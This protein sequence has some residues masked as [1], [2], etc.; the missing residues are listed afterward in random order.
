[1]NNK[2]ITE[3]NR[4]LEI[5]GVNKTLLTESSIFD[6]II[7]LAKPIFAT[8]AEKFATSK[9]KN[10]FVGTEEISKELL[11]KFLKVIDNPSKLVNLTRK[12][13]LKLYRILATDENLVNHVYQKGMRD[14]IKRNPQYT[15]KDLVKKVMTYAAN[16]NKTIKESLNYTFNDEFLTTLLTDKYIKKI[17]D[18]KLNRFVDEVTPIVDDIIEPGWK[19][20]VNNYLLPMWAKYYKSLIPYLTKND[21]QLIDLANKRLGIIKE[22]LSRVPA[23]KIHAD[24]EQLFVILNARKKW[25][26]WDIDTGFVKYLKNNSDLPENQLKQFLE[27]PEVAEVINNQSKQ[28]SSV[29]KDMFVKRMEAFLDQIPGISLI[30]DIIKKGWKDANKLKFF[31]NWKRIGST[32]VWKNPQL[33]SEAVSQ[34]MIAGTKSHMLGIVTNFIVFELV[35][36]PTIVASLKILFENEGIINTL[37]DNIDTIKDMCSQGIL[38]DC[39]ENIEEIKN[40]NVQNWKDAYI[41]SLPFFSMAYNEAN[42]RNTI[43]EDA[44]LSQFT[45]LDEFTNIMM[46]FY[47]SSAF[48]PGVEEEANR[49]ANEYIKKQHKKLYDELVRRGLDPNGGNDVISVLDR[50]KK[51]DGN[52]NG[53]NNGGNTGG[54][55]NGG[56]QVDP[57]INNNGGQPVDPPVN[58]TDKEEVELG[59]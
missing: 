47:K 18:L 25:N 57:P 50:I 41:E 29:V 33:P 5:M 46:R 35:I 3:V 19:G 26:T 30:Q 59:L 2:I 17:D 27:R 13:L 15:E 43:S 34:A 56:Q 24:L 55:N 1:M 23:L 9:G 52:N 14:F 12:E 51:S 10:I 58:N 28:A 38:E 42:P 40:L 37:N 20:T 4:T 11:K 22:K 32:I 54:N 39:P 49:M 8:A 21:E 7:S 31:G 45:F 6:E 44:V 53:R 36:Q 48:G 16:N